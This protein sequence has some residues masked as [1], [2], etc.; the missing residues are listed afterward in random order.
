MSFRRSLIA[1]GV[2]LSIVL[3]V[4]WA[5]GKGLKEGVEGLFE[6][7]WSRS[8]KARGDAEQRYEQ[9][10]KQAPD[11]VASPTPTP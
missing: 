6:A 4:A 1:V 9:L 8:V 10:R 11:D 3:S 7:G 2:G 5:E